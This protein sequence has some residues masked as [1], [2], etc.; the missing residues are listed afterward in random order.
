MALGPLP[1]QQPRAQ[2]PEPRAGRGAG[3]AP[4]G[5]GKDT[6]SPGGSQVRRPTCDRGLGGEDQGPPR[7]S[8]GETRPL[9]ASSPLS[10]HLQRQRPASP[11]LPS[12]G[13]SPAAP[14]KDICGRTW[15]PPDDPHPTAP[16]SDHVCK[17][18]PGF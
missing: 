7:R 4:D 18:P 6:A 9:G 15:S 5:G 17:V 13:R 12:H 3:R 1:S 2:T 11:A 14:Y 8:R 16:A 10:F